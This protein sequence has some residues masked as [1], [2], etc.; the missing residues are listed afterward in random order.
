MECAVTSTR[1]EL[2]FLSK[3]CHQHNSGIILSP[4]LI[5]MMQE[6]HSMK[7]TFE[8]VGRQVRRAVRA[9]YRT[10]MVKHLGAFVPATNAKFGRYCPKFPLIDI[11]FMW[12]IYESPE[13]SVKTAQNFRSQFH[14]S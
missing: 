6:V 14:Y 10:D 2:A 3:I 11:Q 12:F 4:P 1:A 5:L 9:G 8:A 13:N 7:R